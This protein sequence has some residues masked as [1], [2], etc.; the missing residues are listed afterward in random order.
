MIY[1]LSVLAGAIVM[2]GYTLFV[3]HS[4]RIAGIKSIS[5]KLEKP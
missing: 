5:R 1:I 3:Y 4:G 2:I